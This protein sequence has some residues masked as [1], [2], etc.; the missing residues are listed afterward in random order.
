MQ[1]LEKIKNLIREHKKDI[2]KF[3]VKKIGIFGSIVRGA[4]KEDNDIDVLV[5]FDK[6]TFDNYMDLKFYLE[7]LFERKVDLVI[8]RNLREELQYVREEAAY[9]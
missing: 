7:N 9:T 8:E 3:G 1:N 2:E 5:T 6:V 4:A